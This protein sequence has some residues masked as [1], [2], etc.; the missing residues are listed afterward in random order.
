MKNDIYTFFGLLWNC[1]LK[2][3]ECLPRISKII[4][5]GKWRVKT[6]K[7]MLFCQHKSILVS[8]H[9]CSKSSSSDW[10]NVIIILITQNSIVSNVTWDIVDDGIRVKI[11]NP[12]SHKLDVDGHAETNRHTAGKLNI[13]KCR[14]RKDEQQ[15]QLHCWCLQW[16]C[17][18]MW[19]C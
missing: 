4:F 16:S 5:L 10:E 13:L 8:I 6:P 15:S 11:E 7:I 2:L 9:R 18:A 12:Q 19:S 1:Y 17:Y 3:M 14:Y